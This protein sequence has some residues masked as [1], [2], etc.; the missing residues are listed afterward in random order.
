MKC[1]KLSKKVIKYLK[2]HFKKG[3]FFN[4]KNKILIKSKD[5]LLYLK[6]KEGM[7]KSAI[8]LVLIIFIVSYIYEVIIVSAAQ[9]S[10]TITTQAEWEAGEYWNNQLDTKT[11]NGDLKISSGGV[12]SW[13]LD[14]PGFPVNDHG[15]L[16]YTYRQPYWGA[17][18]TT[19]GTY[20]YMIVGYNNSDFFRYNPELGTWQEL[21]EAPTAFYLGSSLAYY[22]GY[23]YAING[24]DGSDATNAVPY[25]FRYDIA[26]DTWTQ[27]ADAPGTWGYGSDIVSGENGKLYAVRARAYDYFW[28]YDIATNTWSD[29]LPNIPSPYQVYS[30][31]GHPLVFSDV[32]YGSD[33]TN[34]ENGCIYSFRGNNNRQFFRFDI[35]L[36]Q[37]YSGF[38]DIPSAIGG[39]HY[40]SSIVF[41]SV[42]D[43][44]YASRG[45][46]TDEFMKYDIDTETWDSDTA[47]T[48]NFPG[49]IATYYGGAMVYHDGYVYALPA[50]RQPEFIRYN[51]TSGSW[52]SI[53]TPAAAS[54][55]YD[56]NLMVFVPSGDD[57]EDDEGCLFV[58]RGRNTDTFWRYDISTQ[59]WNTMEVVDGNLEI[60]S[61]MC[62]DGNNNLYVVQAM[63][64]TNIYNYNIADDDWTSIAGMPGAAEE[65][66]GITCFGD[67]DFFVL[68]GNYSDEIYRYNGSWSTE[69]LDVQAYYGGAI[70]NNGSKV[71]VLA[72]YFRAQF[73]E[74]DVG[75]DTWK[76][77]TNLP[78]GSYYNAVLEYDSTD[79]IYAISG[80]YG[81]NMYRYDISEDSWSRVA[82][83]PNKF[84]RAFSLAHDD[85]NIMYVRRGLDT[86]SIYKYN[87][88]T[89]NYIPS[90]TWI[91]DT[92]DLTY[93]TSFPDGSSF[94]ANAVTPGDTSI[95][96]YSRTST[97]QVSWSDWAE[98]SGDNISS[99]AA[100]YIQIKVVLN[101]DDD[102][103]SSLSDFTITYDKDSDAPSNPVATGYKDSTKDSEI[104]SGSTYYYVNPYFELSGASDAGSGVNGYYLAWTNETDFDPTS[105]EDYFQIGTTYEVNTN[106]TS[107]ETYYLRV[108]A[109]D[110]AGN[111]AEAATLFTYTYNGISPASSKSWTTQDDFEAADTSESNINTAAGSGTNMMLDSV[112]NG[113]W[114]N[115]AALPY[116]N[117][118]GAYYGTNIA[119]N[120]DDTIF[121]LRG[122]NRQ[123]FFA[124]SV[125][126]KTYT[127]LENYGTGVYQG[128]SMAFV[129]NGDDCDDSQGCV[130]ATAGSNTDTFKRYDVSANS[131]TTLDAFDGNEVYYGS[132][133]AY[134]GQGNIYMTRGDNTTQFWKYSIGGDSWT[135]LTGFDQNIYYGGTLVY[136]PNG[137][138]CT[139]SGGCLFASR[140]STDS[141]FY[142]YEVSLNS[143]TYMRNIPFWTHYGATAY[144][145]E[146][147]VYLIRGYAANN[148]LHYDIVGDQWEHLDDLPVT[149][150]Q[151][152]ATN[153]VYVPSNDR[154]YTL[155]GYRYDASFYTYD[156]SEDEWKTP[157]IP[158]SLTNR[159]PYY[160]TVAYD[161][162]NDILYATKGNNNSDFYSYDIS[163]DIWQRK[164]G[165]PMRGRP[166]S[167]M[168]F[169]DH[170]TDQY[171]GIYYLSGESGLA[172]N[173]GTFWYYDPDTDIWNR[174]NN[175]PAENNYGSDLVFDGTDTFYTARG[176]NTTTYY[177]YTISTDTWETVVSN[178]PGNVYTGGCAVNGGDGYIYLTRGNNQDDIY[179]FDINDQ[180]WDAAGTLATAPGAMRYGDACVLDGQGNILIPRGDQA[181]GASNGL[182]VYDISEDSWTQRDYLQYYEYGDLVMTSDN[183]IL[184][185]RGEY[186]N[187]IERYVV[188]T[189]STGFKG[190]G[191]WTCEII[192]FGAGV[193]GY[194]G[195]E[196][197]AETPLGTDLTIETRT[198]DDNVCTTP[199]DW[200]EVSNRR[201]L[202]STKYYSVDTTVSQYGQIKISFTSDQL[203]S[204]TINDITWHYYT[205][206]TAPTNPSSVSAYT[207]EG[208]DS[209]TDNI[210]SG[211]ATPYF[212][213]TAADNAGGIGIK[214]FYLYFGND[215][216][217]DPINDADDATNLAY[218]NDTNFYSVESNGTNGSWNASTQAA[219]SI[220]SDTYY[221]KIRTVD[222]NL[223]QAGDSG[224]LFTFKLDILDPTEPTGISA[225]PAGYSSSD[226]FNFSWTA[227]SDTGGSGVSQY[228]Y[229]TNG[230]DTCIDA[231]STNVENIIS[232]QTR[233]NTFSIRAKDEAGNYSNYSSTTYFY[234]G[235]PPTAPQLVVPSP[236]SAVN[237]N[238]FSFSW[239]LPATCLGQTPCEAADVLRYCYTIN[240]LPSVANCGTN[241]GG[242]ATPSPDGGWTTATQATNR[243]LPGF[244][245]ATQQGTNTIYFVA[246]DAI[247]NIDYDNYTSATY[248]FTSTAP[249]PPGSAQA[250]DSS[251][252]LNQKFQTTLTWNEPSD[253][254]A[255]VENYKIYRCDE[256]SYACDNPDTEDDPPT[257]Y[258]KIA[259]T[260]TTG[261]FDTGLDNTI[262]YRYFIRAVGPGNATSGNSAVVNI[263][264][265]GK[266][267]SAPLMTGQVS[268]IPKVTTATV[269]WYTQDD[270]D[271][272]GNVIPHPASSF[273]EFGETSSYGNETG[274]SE[275]VNEHT[276]TLTGLMADTT[277]YGIAKW[278]DV[279]GNEGNSSEFNFTTLGAPSAPT[280]VG[281]DPAIG[282]TNRFTFNWEAPTDEGIA[283]GG[284]FYSVNTLPNE[285]N[286]YFTQETSIGP[287]RAATQQGKNTFYVV[288]TDDSGNVN[289][290]SYATVEFEAYTPPPP[291]PLDL[292]IEDSSNR[293]TKN[294]L[295]T[296]TWSPPEGFET[297]GMKINSEE[298][299]PE[300][301]SYTVWRSEDIDKSY[302]EI[303]KVTSTA[304]LDAGLE[305]GQEYYYKVTAADSAGSI[306]E[307]SQE[308]SEVPTGRYTT[309]PTITESPSITPDSFSS[310]VTWRTERVASSFVEYGL[311]E[312][313]LT[314]EQGTSDMIEGH[315]VKLT[316]LAAET[317]YYYRIKSI[318]VDENV[319]YSSVSSF[320]TLEAPR[321]MN[322]KITDVRLYD[323]IVSWETNKDSTAVIQYGNTANY[324]LTY[325]DTS[326]SYA[327]THTVKLENLKD[328]T[329]YHLRIGGE[330]RNGN[331][332]TSD[333]YTFT[334]LTFP[335]I[336]DVRTENKAEGQTEIFWTT[337][338]PTSSI[339]E[340]YSP[341]IAP[342][343][344]GNTA[345]VT[346]HA[347]LLFDLNDA[348]RYTFKV[349]GS[350]AFGYEAVSEE[351]EF[352]T[353]EDTTPPEIFGVSSESNTIGS[354]E[355][356]KV[357]IIINWK[358]DEAT[359]SQVEYGVGL[360]S[361]DYTDQTEEEA[362]LVMDHLVVISDLSPA[363]TYH[364]R[365]VSRDKA[366]NQTKSGSYTVLTSRK[367]ESFLQLIISNLEETFSW[368]GNIGDAF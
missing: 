149:H 154:M 294:Y 146:G 321:V 232:Y 7:K 312:N 142:K 42:N 152:G 141:D 306:S 129:P 283:I 303:A 225:S 324:G 224:T 190:Y 54:N 5:Y 220:T 104:S 348:T 37:W 281:V 247:N 234:A 95:D 262:T 192:D 6:K 167:D 11:S 254:G 18:L 106:M 266:F 99:S 341:E 133:M 362:E 155:R 295:V 258:T 59:T 364:F 22:D 302:D 28:S 257:N 169:I 253:V 130:Y 124:Y 100:R 48:P 246:A 49:G 198:C 311:S 90:A 347:V 135:Q 150:Y 319:A 320:T 355:T 98:I 50:N 218:V 215:N 78:Q 236:E 96:Y 93:A 138:Y 316:G 51:I 203:Y 340:Y 361:S 35:A 14:T 304:Y 206:N 191:S 322:V 4:Y 268:V 338:V 223:N 270:T 24:Q 249:G 172:E 260:T 267:V 297:S 81:Q 366:G 164:S 75:G 40:G 89:D 298:E 85:N 211:D 32:S 301:L 66:A 353:L 102:N 285:D 173:E 41:D 210:W 335:E 36:S 73:Y 13:S 214:G 145:K 68:R 103:T 12:G 2:K 251:D 196:V 16:G 60:G 83:T 201:E 162:A 10:V 64:G 166:G 101:S 56:G 131:W 349:R 238:S 118:N 137:D 107:G 139:D 250:I 277:Y 128:A 310:V 163:E 94:S 193:Y 45:Y 205:D 329:T 174:L 92:I 296:L 330:D 265:E 209:I 363:K 143:W 286:V 194:G 242:S 252:R 235:D 233:G 185:F 91:S 195:V 97:D 17:D 204:P 213:W 34:C 309:P 8:I 82:D 161:Q 71:Y 345:L 308:V 72:G 359:T 182:F 111:T 328:G 109:K 122:Y 178:I 274:S 275:L 179:R 127:S 63:D 256:N 313:E 144:Y 33:P 79:N 183:V 176:S 299:D 216:S 121:V 280:N 47:D 44:F 248:E 331:P 197:N 65:G 116:T 365:V 231:S 26:S 212:E 288:A 243:L 134:D 346:E 157:A 123:E 222:H 307:A 318:D 125:S 221:L 291:Q 57:C 358:T 76:E 58:A 230:D 368:L 357:Q 148:F 159:G 305:G 3:V 342:K 112:D 168:E 255:G 227:S 43:N 284:Y 350:D 315:E 171:D 38:A 314:E 323:G 367:R 237:T 80:D 114:T 151:T 189:E 245:A 67:N 261:Y 156:V 334:T 228:C 188:A 239:S 69:N 351:N 27:M 360:G 1:G 336:S 74:Y 327:K 108:S 293:D 207:E 55:N 332:I 300:T 269:E 86:Q 160:G 19:D 317:K 170:D 15:Y 290:N 165:A 202:S 29:T 9:D 23:I 344:Q 115:E 229:K 263:K 30:Q 180:T 21:S 244:S 226:S 126:D 217:K 292:F 113:I 84:F 219:A 52:D 132:T 184:G 25:L 287:Y 87:T 136:V 208:G 158:H 241:V 61:S 140:G 147:Y 343:T 282:Y 53:I 354:G 186:S 20:I 88:E 187:A 77:L 326:G 276:V 153:L 289:Y 271:Q 264:P 339:V 120:N 181:N 177:K 273:I 279:D 278:L 110:D 259:E 46:N 337:N 240:E 199:G 39:V 333:D 105:S 272:Q 31:N 200:T 352:V 119:Y 175:L 117:N 62:Y 70:T 356:S 325:T